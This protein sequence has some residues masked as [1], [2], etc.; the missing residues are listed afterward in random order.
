MA[1]APQRYPLA[2]PA[3]RPR[4]PNYRR[5]S[6]KFKKNDRRINMVDAFR[7]VDE[8]LQRMGARYQILST[9]IELRLDGIPRGGGRAPDDPGVC[10]YFHLKDKPF[11]LACDSYIDVAQNIAALAAHLDATRAIERHGVATAAETLEA[12]TALPPPAGSQ[13]TPRVRSWREVLGLTPHFPE[14]LTPKE[15]AGVVQGRFRDRATRA[16]PDTGGSTEAMAELN[17][18]RTAALLEVNP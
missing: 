11:A 10:L 17:A 9:N 1:D 16:H 13:P 15:A 8:E 7:R 3:H 6:G 14:G 12:F 4:T 5:R 18:A 2:W